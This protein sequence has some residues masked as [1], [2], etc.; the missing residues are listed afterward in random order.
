MLDVVLFDVL[1]KHALDL[2]ALDDEQRAAAFI[3]KVYQDFKQTM[4]EVNI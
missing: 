3:I 2:S 4:M 1:T